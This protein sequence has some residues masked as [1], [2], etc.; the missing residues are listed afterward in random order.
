MEASELA[1][2]V[3]VSM[4]RMVAAMIKDFWELL[5][6]FATAINDAGPE[7]GGAMRDA[8]FSHSTTE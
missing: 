5:D 1:S 6:P 8:S 4:G 2:Q 3:A 7:R